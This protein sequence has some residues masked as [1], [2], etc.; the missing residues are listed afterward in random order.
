M[1]MVSPFR[2]IK[3]NQWVYFLSGYYGLD[4]LESMRVIKL[5]KQEVAGHW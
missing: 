4:L 5:R 1:E 3:S 2:D